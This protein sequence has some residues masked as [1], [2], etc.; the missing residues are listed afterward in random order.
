MISL[1]PFNDFRLV[2][3]P[4]DSCLFGSLFPRPHG[5]TYPTPAE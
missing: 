4:H 5:A 3:F 1:L 2:P